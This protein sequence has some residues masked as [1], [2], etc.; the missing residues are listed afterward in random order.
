MNKFLTAYHTLEPIITHI[1]HLLK[2]KEREHPK[3]RKPILSNIEAAICAILQQKQNIATKKMNAQLKGLFIA[4]AGY[5][6]KELEREFFIE[7]ERMMITAT[8]K[9]MK[10]ITAPTLPP[11]VKTVDC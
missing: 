5:V 7:H 9:N 11:V 6:S 8:R 4:E 2:L 1:F 3:G 10:K